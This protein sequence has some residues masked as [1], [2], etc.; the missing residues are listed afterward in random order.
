MCRRLD[1]NDENERK[2]YSGAHNFSGGGS[3]PKPLAPHRSLLGVRRYAAHSIKMIIDRRIKISHTTF[4][5]QY[6]IPG[7]KLIKNG[8]IPVLYR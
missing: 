2:W 4:V 8:Q 3:P 7:N 1:K 6:T 5:Y